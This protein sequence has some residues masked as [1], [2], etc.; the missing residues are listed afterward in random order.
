MLLR[1]GQFVMLSAR[2]LIG[3]WYE[4][5]IS[6][7]VT[8]SR[9]HQICERWIRR[10]CFFISGHRVSKWYAPSSR[11]DDLNAQTFAESPLRQVQA[12]K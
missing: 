12:L 10:P 1:G 2:S 6:G 11:A 3:L 5:I 8:I 7:G 9:P 4:A